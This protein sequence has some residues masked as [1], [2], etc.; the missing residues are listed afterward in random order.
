MG[1]LRVELGSPKRFA[2]ISPRGMFLLDQTTH[3]CLASSLVLARW[4]PRA[5][6]RDMTP[7]MSPDFPSPRGTK[8]SPVHQEDTCVCLQ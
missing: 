6:P 1:M 4:R 7:K 5:P 3:L 8:D 2:G